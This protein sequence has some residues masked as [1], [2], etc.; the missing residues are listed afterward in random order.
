MDLHIR[1]AEE[2]M[3]IERA[4]YRQIN[5][6]PGGRKCPCCARPSMIQKKLNH[7]AA[8]QFLK[9]DLRREMD[10]LDAGRSD[11]HTETFAG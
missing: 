2:L 10:E 11:Y 6:G 9:M 8:R 4:A 5:V 7:R 3:K 1:E